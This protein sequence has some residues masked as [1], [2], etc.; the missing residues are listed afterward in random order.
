MWAKTGV[1]VV[2]VS[3]GRG[4]QHRRRASAAFAGVIC[5]DHVSELSACC[6]FRTWTV[7]QEVGMLC[8]PI[9]QRHPPV[10]PVLLPQE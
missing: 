7:Q 9:Q 8:E 10:M 4:R 2:S 1:S 5:V 3:A 6:G